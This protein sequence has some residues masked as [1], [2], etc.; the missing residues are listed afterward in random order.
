MCLQVVKLAAIS[1]AMGMAS[2]QINAMSEDKTETVRLS[3]RGNQMTK[4]MFNL[5][6]NRDVLDYYHHA[7]YC[8]HLTIN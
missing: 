8:M 5:L 7:S 6:K 2:F 3:P 1:A 4:M